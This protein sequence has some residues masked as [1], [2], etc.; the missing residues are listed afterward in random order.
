MSCGAFS[1]TAPLDP[2][3]ALIDTCICELCGFEPL[4]G[5]DPSRLSIVGFQIFPPNIKYFVRESP[6]SYSNNLEPY[7]PFFGSFV[8]STAC[9]VL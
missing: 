6:L 2:A 9:A 4:Y 7:T 3:P 5:L 1:Q 8:I